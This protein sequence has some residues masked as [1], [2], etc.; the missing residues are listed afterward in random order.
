ML[1]SPRRVRIGYRGINLGLGT[2][3]LVAL[4]LIIKGIIHPS[5]SPLGSTLIMALLLS[6][7]IV[8]IVA[9]ILNMMD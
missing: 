7:G 8:Q 6:F 1:L 5:I 4:F 9:G 2:L 3:S